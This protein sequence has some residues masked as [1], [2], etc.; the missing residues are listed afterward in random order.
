MQGLEAVP[1]ARE[2]SEEEPNAMEVA[3]EPMRPGAPAVRRAGS[4][5]GLQERTNSE[6]KDDKHP[7]LSDMN[8][9]RPQFSRAQPALNR[10]VMRLELQQLHSA[11]D[12]SLTHLMKEMRDLRRRV[13]A[14]DD[15]IEHVL[16]RQDEAARLQIER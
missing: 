2:N 3:L 13:K 11:L 1:R 4:G 14:L 15:K 10:A 12:G 5:L 9:S 16:D 7:D 6:F 8:L